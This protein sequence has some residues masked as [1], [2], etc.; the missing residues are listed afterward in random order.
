[1]PEG[2][3][4]DFPWMA[5][6]IGAGAGLAYTMTGVGKSKETIAGASPTELA[7]SAVGG[8]LLWRAKDTGDQWVAGAGA[9]IFTSQLASWAVPKAKKSIAGE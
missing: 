9:A 7:L 2:K 1:M 8:A 6:L 5:A 4:D 3:K